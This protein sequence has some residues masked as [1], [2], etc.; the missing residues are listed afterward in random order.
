MIQEVCKTQA[1]KDLAFTFWS[2]SFA[3]AVTWVMLLFSIHR[4]WAAAPFFYRFCMIGLAIAYPYPWTTTLRARQNQ[5]AL[6]GAGSAYLPLF[7][8]VMVLTFY[9]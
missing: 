1:K 4:H 2:N 3:F 6:H 9:D 7:F 8:A 5:E